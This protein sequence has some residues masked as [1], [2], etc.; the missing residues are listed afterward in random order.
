MV[1]ALKKST[2]YFASTYT[3][4]DKGK[5]TCASDP[6]I[7]N[8]VRFCGAHVVHDGYEFTRQMKV[9]NIVE[10]SER[11]NRKI[12]LHVC[13]KAGGA[14]CCL[15]EKCWR[16]LLAIYAEKRAPYDYGLEHDDKK[17]RTLSKKMRY[18]VNKKFGEIFYDST[19]ETMRKNCRRKDLPKSIR[20]FYSADVTKFN[21]DTLPKKLRRKARLMLQ[22]VRG[23]K[24][25]TKTK[26]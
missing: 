20:W 19:Q 18:G 16:T 10:Y 4:A 5:L 9:R 15:C 25:P 17:L 26:E 2:V 23:E 1:Y 22:V 3:I 13:W 7:D 24:K 8:Y 6:T 12:H 21:K 14:N 11:T